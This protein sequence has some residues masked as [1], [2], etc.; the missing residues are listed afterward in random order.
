MYLIFL[1]THFRESHPIIC[2]V[3]LICLAL[4]TTSIIDGGR[5]HSSRSTSR[6]AVFMLI[7]YKSDTVQSFIYLFILNT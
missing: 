4:P 2:G 3:E 5:Q 6:L 7:I 1:E